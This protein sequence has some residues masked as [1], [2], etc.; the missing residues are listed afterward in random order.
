MSIDL[1]RI[2]RRDVI[3]ATGFGVACG[4]LMGVALKILGRE[5][6]LAKASATTVI[7]GSLALAAR[8]WGSAHTIQGRRADKGT[9][10]Q[11][12]YFE[13][14]KQIEGRLDYARKFGSKSTILDLKCQIAQDLDIPIDRLYVTFGGREPNLSH[15]FLLVGIGNNSLLVVSKHEYYIRSN[16]LPTLEGFAS[17]YLKWRNGDRVRISDEQLQN[18]KGWTHE[19]Q[20]S[21]LA[22]VIAPILASW[23]EEI[24]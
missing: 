17:T 15:S 2:D 5:G 11:S 10:I 24:N 7:T 3:W 22:C 20:Y 16:N 23:E 13:M 1:S 19:N 6:L 21:E 14:S 18:W 4:G 12:L 8:G 9:P